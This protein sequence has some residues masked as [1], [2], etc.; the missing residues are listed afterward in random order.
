MHLDGRRIDEGSGRSEERGEAVNLECSD[1]GEFIGSI[2]TTN[3]E[4]DKAAAPVSTPSAPS[5]TASRTLLEEELMETK[6][7]NS[8]GTGCG[9]EDLR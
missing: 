1:N 4:A 3:A 6:Q 8:V 5:T 9:E 2:L 7:L